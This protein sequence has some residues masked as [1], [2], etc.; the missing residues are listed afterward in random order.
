M[1]MPCSQV[2]YFFSFCLSSKY[3][4][5][6]CTKVIIRK[7][8]V[9]IQTSILVWLL[10]FVKSSKDRRWHQPGFHGRL[11]LIQSLLERI[12]GGKKTNKQT[13]PIEAF[14]SR[15][16]AQIVMYISLVDPSLFSPLSTL[17]SIGD[18]H[19]GNLL[20]LFPTSHNRENNISSS[21][22]VLQATIGKITSPLHSF[23]FKP[24]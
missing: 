14:R 22:F 3:S 5:D 15:T 10:S 1:C 16:N 6:F 19:D 12:S 21:F 8:I 2:L 20:Y 23:F 17:S 11:V 13:R 18:G 4:V 7:Y 24:Q 9:P